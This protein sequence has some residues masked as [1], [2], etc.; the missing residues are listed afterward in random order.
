MNTTLLI[1][2]PDCV[3]RGYIGEIISRLEKK[4]LS[5]LAMKMIRVSRELAEQ[6]YAEHKNK[7]FFEDLLRF[8]TS[9]PVVP[10]VVEG[11]NAPPRLPPADRSHRLFSSCR[12]Y[13]PGRLRNERQIQSYPR[14]LI[15]QRAPD[16]RSTS[17]SPRMKS[18]I[19]TVTTIPGCITR[20]INPRS[21][22]F[23]INNSTYNRKGLFRLY[24]IL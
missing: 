6:H 21:N 14:Q 9:R 8:I 12:R 3:A 11:M 16:A 13:Y 20:M 4:G 10:M 5:I 1:L 22:F 24:C 15:P 7:P 19:P 17:G 18:W 2:K 23:N